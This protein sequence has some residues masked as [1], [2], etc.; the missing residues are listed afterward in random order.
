MWEDVPY[1]QGRKMPF[2]FLLIVQ[3]KNLRKRQKTE[4]VCNL[5]YIK[6]YITE[7]FR[8]IFIMVM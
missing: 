3:K 4:I 6:H 5:Y 7:N 2:M 8:G 1:A